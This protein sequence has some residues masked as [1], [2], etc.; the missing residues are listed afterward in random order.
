MAAVT[1]SLTYGDMIRVVAC[2]WL[3][4]AQEQDLGHDALAQ[5]RLPSVSVR[6]DLQAILSEAMLHET[7]ALQQFPVA[8][9][10]GV[11]SS[12]D[13]ASTQAA[14]VVTPSSSSAVPGGLAASSQGRALLVEPGHVVDLPWFEWNNAEEWQE[15]WWCSYDDGQQQ[16]LQEA[17]HAGAESTILDIHGYSYRI[18]LKRRWMQQIALHS[19]FR[20]QVR[21]WWNGEESHC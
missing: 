12:S 11:A 18:L 17:M 3:E 13:T 14:S 10:T 6:S 1:E 5:A 4:Q 9:V 15:P 2:T 7:L 21:V 16:H 8:A 19:G 20:R